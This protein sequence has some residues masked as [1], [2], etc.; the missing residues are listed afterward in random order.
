MSAF[1]HLLQLSLFQTEEY[2][3]NL[4]VFFQFPL[5]N[6]YAVF[7]KKTLLFIADN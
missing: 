1:T 4:K 2:S 6:L 7:L 3:K 5:H